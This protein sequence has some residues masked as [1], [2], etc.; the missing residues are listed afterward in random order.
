MDA[1]ADAVQSSADGAVA[2][3]AQPSDTAIVPAGKY[4]RHALDTRCHAPVPDNDA[5]ADEIHSKCF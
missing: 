2:M 3:D 5:C 4:A 1:V